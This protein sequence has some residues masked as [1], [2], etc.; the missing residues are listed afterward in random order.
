MLA[1]LD[2]IHWDAHRDAYGSA[3]GVPVLLRGL[4]S[5]RPELRQAALDNLYLAICPAQR[6]VAEAAAVAVPFLWELAASPAVR[7]RARVLILLAHI[8]RATGDTGDV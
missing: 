5:A 7:E 3:T 1:G 4:A 6:T 2:T 8:A